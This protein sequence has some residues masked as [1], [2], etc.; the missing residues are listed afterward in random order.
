M[1]K[2]AAAGAGLSPDER[3]VFRSIV[4]RA[5]EVLYACDEALR[6]I[7]R[8]REPDRP[9]VEVTARAG[10]GCGWTEAPRGMLWHRYECD[11][12]G[13]IVD[14]RIVP[15]TSQNQAAIESDLFHFVQRHLDLP[16]EELDGEP[17][18]SSGATTRASPALTHSQNLTVDR[19]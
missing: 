12:E 4:V 16:D 9:A 13:S 11:A 17:S 10:V 18:R 19:A 5:V 3:N 2:A 1:A 7:D 15:P 8:Y 6:I 14:A